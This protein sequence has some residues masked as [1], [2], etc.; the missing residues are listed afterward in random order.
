ML[1]ILVYL[2]KYFWYAKKPFAKKKWKMPKS[3]SLY[4][5]NIRMKNINL[6][7]Y[8]INNVLFK[9]KIEKMKWLYFSQLL[10]YSMSISPILHV[11]FIKYIL[12]Y[13]NKLYIY[14]LLYNRY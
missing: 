3:T 12:K 2:L 5:S 8:I 13:L 6:I 10:T 14:N 9:K 11:Y 1:E 4:K 7:I